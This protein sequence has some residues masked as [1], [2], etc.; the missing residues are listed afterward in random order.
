[1]KREEER[2]GCSP[3][4][5]SAGPSCLSRCTLCGPDAADFPGGDNKM[6]EMERDYPVTAKKRTDN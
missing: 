4:P 5:P 2:K 3:F 1:M 6:A